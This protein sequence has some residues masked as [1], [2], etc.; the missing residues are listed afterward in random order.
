[1]LLSVEHKQENVL[2]KHTNKQ[3]GEGDEEQEDMRNQVESIHKA[4]I[5][6]H[7]II[8][9]V[10]VCNVL[11]SAKCQGHSTEQLGPHF[12]KEQQY[13]NTKAQQ[14]VFSP[15]FIFILSCLFL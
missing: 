14:E 8:Y 15:L 1:M 3:D 9:T 2:L 5:I 10:G 4:A 11:V 13:E 12:C 6:Q 7:A